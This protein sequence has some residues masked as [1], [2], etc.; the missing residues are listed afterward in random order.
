[1]TILLILH[2]TVCVGLFCWIVTMISMFRFFKGSRRVLPSPQHSDATTSFSSA[3]QIVNRWTITFALV[4]MVAHILAWLYGLSSL[5]ESPLRSLLLLVY[6]CFIGGVIGMIISTIIMLPNKAAVVNAIDKAL[7]KQAKLLP[8]RL[9]VIG[10]ICIAALA[11][12]NG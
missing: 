11:F 2:I 4:D 8:S 7:I 9:V 6:I 5:G 3:I 10:V 1:M 12:L